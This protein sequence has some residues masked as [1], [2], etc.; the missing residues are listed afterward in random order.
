MSSDPIADMLSKIR[1]AIRVKF[2]T[3]SITYSRNKKDILLALEK[4]GYIDSFTIEK[5][6]TSNKINLII[7][8]RYSLGGAP[9]IIELKKISKSG[10]RIYLPLQDLISYKEGMGTYILNTSKGVMSDRSAKALKC[11]GEVI[12]R[13]F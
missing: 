3:V 11:G 2:K 1:N 8:L 10:R 5:L 13:V 6:D 7:N 9:A 12:C 4:E